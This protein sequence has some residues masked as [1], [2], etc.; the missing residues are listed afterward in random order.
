[1]MGK[2][3]F[4]LKSATI[5]TASEDGK[6][7]TVQIPLGSLIVV[8]DSVA[9]DSREPNQQVSVEWQGATIKMFAIDIRERG[10]RVQTA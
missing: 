1:M 8:L 4:R 3:R 2:Q 5:A 7:A 6:P 9:F 10:E